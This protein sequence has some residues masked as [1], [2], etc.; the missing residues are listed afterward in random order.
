MARPTRT[1][2]GSAT[3]SLPT[4]VQSDPSFETAA[5]TVV[6]TRVTFNQVGAPVPGAVVCVVRVP[7]AGRRWNASP[8]ASEAKANACADAGDSDALIITPAL[9]QGSVPMT[10]VTRATISP[11]PVMRRYV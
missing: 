6:P 8:S 9:V 7:S 5:V 11:S 10:D 2:D 4:N 1:S 3:V